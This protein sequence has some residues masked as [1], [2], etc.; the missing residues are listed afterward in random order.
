[1]RS[2]VLRVN[3]IL[4]LIAFGLLSYAIKFLFNTYVSNHIDATLYGDFS[5]A[6]RFIWVTVPFVLFGT[7]MAVSKYFTRYASEND[8]SS[9]GNY[10][11]WNMKIIRNSILI[12]FP[13]CIILILII[14]FM[15][16][17]NINHLKNYHMAV[18]AQLAVPSAALAV[19]IGSIFLALRSTVV[20]SIITNILFNL[21]ALFSFVV[22]FNVESSI[23][24]DVLDLALVLIVTS[25]F[26][27]MISMLL[28]IFFYRNRIRNFLSSRKLLKAEDSSDWLGY[29]KVLLMNNSATKLFQFL[30][31]LIVE[32]I[33]VHGENQV[34]YY[35][36][37]LVIVGLV[38]SVV[39]MV[40]MVI[41]PRLAAKLDPAVNQRNLN[42]CNFIQIVFLV[43]FSIIILAYSKHIL[44]LF[45]D[46]YVQH[47]GQ[48]DIYV[49][50]S[51]FS[52]I[53]SLCV[54]D[55][56]YYGYHKIL[57]LM[58]SVNILLIVVV[59]PFAYYFYNLTGMVWSVVIINNIGN[60]S[61]FFYVHRRSKLKY[62]FF[63]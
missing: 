36:S 27:F 2:D 57:L 62:L 23:G 61:L 8:D 56:L 1:M 63:L 31:L 54:Y 28:I 14:A 58:T 4:G 35:G 3:G 55:P 50:G 12:F 34:G 46:D 42:L 59:C 30:D 49:V 29:S 13:L 60:Y 38:Y 18:Y 10:L 9:A 37:F 24:L 44:H 48:L 41:K 33:G 5:L 15:I 40:K 47:A 11:H 21:I 20:S 43:I 16:H 52:L 53:P 39:N 45:G 25:L 22:F 51:V 26:Y 6:I 17:Y 32:V 7:N 19:I